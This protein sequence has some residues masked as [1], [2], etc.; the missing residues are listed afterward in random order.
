MKKRWGKTPEGR[1]KAPI[2]DW[3]D[4]IGACWFMPVKSKFGSR[5]V[6]YIG[7]WQ[8]VAFA[9]EAKRPG[10]KSGLTNNQ[11]T[12][13]ANWIKAGGWGFLTD[14]LEDLQTQWELACRIAGIKTQDT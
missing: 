8:G 2:S 10:G 1:V 3:L 9:I 5:S 12:F 13:L 11:K 6:D 14:S 7:V 4:T